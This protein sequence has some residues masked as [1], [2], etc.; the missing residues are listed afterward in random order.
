MRIDRVTLRVWAWAAIAAVAAASAYP[1][2]QSEGDVVAAARDGFDRTLDQYVREG[3]VYYRALQAERAQ[4]DRFVVAIAAVS[5]TA[6]PRDD[7]LAFWL[8]AYNALVLQT[9]IDRYPSGSRSALYPPGSIRQIPGAFE[10]VEHRVA[11]QLLTLDQ[12][13]RIELSGFGDPRVYFALGRGAVGGGRL[14]SAAFTGDDVDRQLSAVAAECLRRAQCAQI[15]RAGNQVLASSV[16]SWRSAAFIAS[17]ASDADHLFMNRSPI[18]QA[19][20]AYIDPHL[21]A[22]EREFLM[23]NG[24]ELRFAPFDWELNDLTGR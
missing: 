7:R 23:R 6:V 12:I 3:L 15:D 4:L 10:R 24:F 22:A 11:G 9:V 20:L 17:Y 2:A 1:R 21:L 5:L 14:R 16:F 13:E 8:N 18:E 19:V